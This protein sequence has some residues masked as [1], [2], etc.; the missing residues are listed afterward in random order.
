M[1]PSTRAIIHKPYKTGPANI[2]PYVPSSACHGFSTTSCH[3]KK[4]TLFRLSKSKLTI[5]ELSFASRSKRVF[6]RN[7]AHSNL[8]PLQV[9]FHPN[10]NHFHLKGYTK[11]M[12]NGS[13][14]K[15]CGGFCI[16][17]Y[18]IRGQNLIVHLLCWASC[19]RWSHLS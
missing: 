16:S 1:S 14:S 15:I 3:P 10:Q 6:V 13:F 2:R 9:H 11:G 4:K 17:F 7:H 19:F 8:F 18:P 5:S 12:V